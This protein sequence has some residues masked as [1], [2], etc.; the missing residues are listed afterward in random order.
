MTNETDLNDAPVNQFCNQCPGTGWLLRGLKCFRE[1][2]RARACF[3]PEDRGHKNGPIIR[4][5]I[6]VAPLAP[7][8]YEITK[9]EICTAYVAGQ[10]LSQI[11][12][13]LNARGVP[14]KHRKT[15]CPATVRGII[16]RLPRSERVKRDL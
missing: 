15:W 14:T 16:L 11:S 6:G 2:G 10:T 8:L 9:Q 13:D 3:V 4:P 1:D 12:K 5:P 7:D